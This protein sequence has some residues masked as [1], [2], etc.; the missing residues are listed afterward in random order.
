MVTNQSSPHRLPV[1]ARRRVGYLARRGGSSRPHLRPRCSAYRAPLYGC[2]A[3]PRKV[4]L[5]RSSSPSPPRPRGSSS[6]KQDLVP[7][8]DYVHDIKHSL[9][10]EQNRTL[11][12]CFLKAERSS[13][14]VLAVVDHEVV[15]EGAIDE[16][17]VQIEEAEA[18]RVELHRLPCQNC[19]PCLLTWPAHH[20]LLLSC[21]K[22]A[23]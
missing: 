16:H 10:Q 22:F 6:C 9:F 5:H 21:P 12:I 7:E 1:Q 19:W 2:A 18:G 14:R 15:G 23:R 3:P 20:S 4:A 11:P 8:L 17:L 13:W